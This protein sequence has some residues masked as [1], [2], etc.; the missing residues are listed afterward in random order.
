M[1]NT[2]STKKDKEL[3]TTKNKKET[4]ANTLTKKDIKTQKIKDTIKTE[5]KIKTDKKIVKDVN[6]LKQFEEKDDIIKIENKSIQKVKGI[7][8][9]EIFIAIFVILVFLFFEALYFAINQPRYDNQM[10][11][12]HKPIIYLYPEYTIDV[13]VKLDYDGKIIA[14]LPK[15]DKEIKGWD[16]IAYPDS[17]IID[18]SDNK[19]YSYLFWEGIPSTEI[20]W[21]F[22]KGFVVKGSESREF[23]QDILP[24]IGLTPKEFNEFIV[25]WYPIMQK[26]EYNL[27]NFSGKQYTDTAPLET[28]PKYDSLLR[29]FMVFKAIDKPINISPQTFDKFERKGFTVVEWGGTQVK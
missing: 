19:E 11:V 18:K 25:Y 13:K 17:K 9:K 16:V 26:N 4:K 8:F 3:N 27:V 15:Y 28:I 29:V 1:S 24:K 2:K 20:S 21:N 7:T 6:Q 5:K 14:D 23:L 22:D 10:R 12:L